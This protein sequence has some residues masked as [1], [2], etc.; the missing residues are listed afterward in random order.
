MES[1][2]V[3][4]EAVATVF[5][6]VVA[7]IAAYYAWRQ[8]QHNCRE[9]ERTNAAGVSAWWGTKQKGAVWGVCVVNASE[10]PYYE[11][12]VFTEGNRNAKG[13]PIKFGT[14][15]PGCYF[16]ESGSS[17][18][19]GWCNPELITVDAGSIEP[20]IN[21]PKHHVNRLEYL[22]GLGCSWGG[23]LKK[24]SEEE[25]SSDHRRSRVFKGA[26]QG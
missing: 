13:V 12:K 17:S 7:G 3:W 8:W 18:R 16:V 23:R 24:V 25:L 20:V 19:A 9:A 14:L 11:V 6:F 21:S 1:W 5:G 10:R 15:P 22:D 2:A 4:V 26:R